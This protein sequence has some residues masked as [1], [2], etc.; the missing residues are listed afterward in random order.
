MHGGSRVLDAAQLLVERV[1]VREV[2]LAAQRDPHRAGLELLDRQA[3]ALHRC[4]L[5]PCRSCSG[6]D[7]SP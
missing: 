7:M 4:L 3:E 6:S 5:S 2:E 1:R